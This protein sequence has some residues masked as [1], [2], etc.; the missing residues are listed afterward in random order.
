MLAA[1]MIQ[2]SSVS[3]LMRNMN[4]SLRVRGAPDA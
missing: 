1:A 3:L 2:R 4:P